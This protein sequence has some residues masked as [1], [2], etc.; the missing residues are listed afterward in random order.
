MTARDIGSIRVEDGTSGERAQT[1]EAVEQ[2][3]GNATFI[4]SVLLTERRINSNTPDISRLGVYSDDATDDLDATPPHTPVSCGDKK[5]L[6]VQIVTSDTPYITPIGYNLAGDSVTMLF[7]EKSPVLPMGG[8]YRKSSK[9]E[10]LN[11]V[12]VWDILGAEKI[13]IAITGVGKGV[14]LRAW[15]I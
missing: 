6:V 2:H 5:T 3:G 12:M 8:T 4:Q 1:V 10:T 14:D 9:E 11:Q 15:L 7:E 13:C